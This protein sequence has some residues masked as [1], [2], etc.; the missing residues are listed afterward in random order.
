[1]KPLVADFV[2]APDAATRKSVADRIQA[3]AYANAPAVMWG[4][5]T[6]PSGYRSSLS[7]L[8]ESSFPMFWQVDKK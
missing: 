1:M 4:Q 5:F 2:K 8:V 3:L 6:V 7:G